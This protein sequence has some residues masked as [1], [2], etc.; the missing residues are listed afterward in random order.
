MDGRRL[1]LLVYLNPGWTTE[2]G[3]ALRLTPPAAFLP[4]PASGEEVSPEA[5]DV[6]PVGGRMVLFYSAE[7][8]HEVMPTFGDRHAITIWRV[9]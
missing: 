3:G 5:I 2:Q 4:P 9:I 1:T 6:Y 8:P 7:I